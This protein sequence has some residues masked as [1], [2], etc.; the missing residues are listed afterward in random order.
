M[1]I[2]RMIPLLLPLLSVFV[3]LG[4][5]DMVPSKPA[6]VDWKAAL[7]SRP[8]DVNTLAA[9]RKVKAISDRLGK[10]PAGDGLSAAENQDLATINALSSIFRD[11]IASAGSP[12]LLPFDLRKA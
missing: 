9:L 8:L 10:Q 12:V 4:F 11:K 7:E 2:F 5:A 1:R 3:D 6:P